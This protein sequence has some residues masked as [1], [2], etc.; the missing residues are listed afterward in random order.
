M[1]IENVEWKVFQHPEREQPWVAL[2]LATDE[3]PQGFYSLNPWAGRV[4]D[5]AARDAVAPVLLGEDPTEIEDLWWKMRRAGVHISVLGVADVALWD[6]AARR[7]GCPAHALLGTKRRRIRVYRSTPFN[8][9]SPEDYAEY[10]LAQR[11][12]GYSGVKIH[13]THNDKWT[14]GEARG[15]VDLDVEIARTVRE[16]M[17]DDFPLMWDNYKTYTFDEAVRVGRVLQELNYNWYESPMPET[18]DWMDRYLQLQ[19]HLPDLRLCAPETHPGD[20]TDRIRW[21][22]AGATD[23]GRLDVFFGGIT[24]CWAV[25]EECRRQGIQ[26]DLHS[27]PSPQMAIYGATTD[28]LMPFM[29]HFGSS[30]LS[31]QIE[32]D[33]RA[34]IPMEPAAHSG[35]DWDVV[36]ANELAENPW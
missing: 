12:D 29:E 36:C 20:H 16:A 23:M 31:F 9:G 10:A 18:D 8:V 33:G 2:R 27:N 35:P 21:I 11:A 24:S 19:E 1:K 6:M 22:R 26:M 28:D 7:A 25:A 34:S 17:G 15:D 3:G 32:E 5:P 13:A 4:K 30:N 14:D